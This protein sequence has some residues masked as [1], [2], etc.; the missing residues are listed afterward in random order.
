[1]DTSQNDK[2]AVV[3]HLQDISEIFTGCHF[4]F[5]FLSNDN[6]TLFADNF[7]REFLEHTIF[8][9]NRATVSMFN[10]ARTDRYFILPSFNFINSTN[11]LE[12]STCLIH[13]CVYSEEEYRI[14]THF[15][16]HITET[17]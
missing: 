14:Q 12:T 16:A 6:S 2:L 10:Y 15:Y 11:T 3:Q 7:M 8:M 5:L 17:M 9:K 4:Q 1:M 13:V